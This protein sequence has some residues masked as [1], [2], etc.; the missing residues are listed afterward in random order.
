MAYFPADHSLMMAVEVDTASEVD[1]AAAPSAQPMSVRRRAVLGVVG[2]VAIVAAGAA[3]SSLRAPARAT[4]SASALRSASSLDGSISPASDDDTISVY[5][6]CG[7]FWHMQHG[8]TEA[9]MSELSREGQD[10]TARAGYAGGTQLGDDG[11]VCYHNAQHKADYGSLGHAEVVLLTIPKASFGSFAA[12]FWNLC[13]NGRRQDPQDR[14]GEYRSVVGLPGGMD[15]PLLAKLQEGAGS[16]K[17]VAGEGD[18]GDTLPSGEVLVH[19]QQSFPAH[20]AEKFHQFHDDMV[21]WY[22]SEYNSLSRFAA[23]T[24]C[25]GD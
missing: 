13:P 25:P 18:E 16:A 4:S 21:E 9:E 8:L 20:V 15:S 5:F 1:E 17:I 6:G 2:A 19:D 24:S 11:L 7:C 3:A 14:G 10:I 12:A 22:G 23:T